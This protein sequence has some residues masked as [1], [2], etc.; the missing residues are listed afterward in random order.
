MAQ[1]ALPQGQ[2]CRYDRPAG[3]HS[4]VEL[5]VR[6]GLGLDALDWVASADAG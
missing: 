5:A 3:E 2:P 6:V 1:P 4:P